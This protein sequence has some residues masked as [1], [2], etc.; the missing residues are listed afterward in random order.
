MAEF[1]LKPLN[2]LDEGF[3][4][5]NVAVSCDVTHLVANTCAKLTYKNDTRSAQNATFMWPGWY[6]PIQTFEAND[7][8][9]KTRTYFTS[10]NGNQIFDHA[11]MKSGTRESSG[12]FQSSWIVHLSNL[13]QFDL[14]TIDAQASVVIILT[15]VSTLDVNV[16]TTDKKPSHA[17][18]FDVSY[19]LL[20]AI[21]PDNRSPG[22]CADDTKAL[23][24]LESMSSHA[25]TF[26][27][28]A[29]VKMPATIEAVLSTT[30]QYSVQFLTVNHRSAHIVLTSPFQPDH[31]LQMNIQL[32]K[33]DRLFAFA[34]PACG[35]TEVQSIPST[36]C[37]F[38]CFVPECQDFLPKKDM[39]KELVLLIDRSSE[40]ICLGI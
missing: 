9:N 10:R 5:L 8:T 37:L 17:S 12:E 35:I 1:G 11:P 36:D 38:L 27:F 3:R 19:T 40:L 20:N 29:Y 7:G 34:E 25:Y 23:S 22:S 14:G 4:L 31:E 33:S 18:H 16:L 32:G 26:S 30:D 2:P 21:T 15:Y 28:E 39:Q 13:V 6:P 24:K